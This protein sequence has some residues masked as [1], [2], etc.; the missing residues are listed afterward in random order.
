M[1]TY[2]LEKQ[3]VKTPRYYWN[4]LLL[5]TP[6]P[7]AIHQCFAEATPEGGYVRFLSGMTASALRPF[8]YRP[9][10]PTQQEQHSE[11]MDS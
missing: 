5:Q 7:R 1:A 10:Q 3:V 2:W 8:V 4:R 6:A 9:P 11:Q